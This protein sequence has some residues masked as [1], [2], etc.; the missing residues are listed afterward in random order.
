MVVIVVAGGVIVLVVICVVVVDSS[1]GDRS[2]SCLGTIL[3]LVTAVMALVAI[4]S[5]YLVTW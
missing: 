5:V 2:G 4:S 1:S 3:L